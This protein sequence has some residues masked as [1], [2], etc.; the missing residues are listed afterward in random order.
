MKA[1]DKIR[2]RFAETEEAPTIC[3]VTSLLPNA[4]VKAIIDDPA[5]PLHKHQGKPRELTIAPSNYETV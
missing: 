4:W 5:H 1:G 3:T 2:I